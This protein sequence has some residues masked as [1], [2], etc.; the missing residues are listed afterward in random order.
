MRSLFVDERRCIGCL[1]CKESCPEGKIRI[2]DDE[3]REIIFPS[4]CGNDCTICEEACQEKAISLG[5]ERPGAPEI[6]LRFHLIPCED[7]LRGFITEPMLER[8][9][10][11]IP[12]DLQIDSSGLSWLRLCP[13]CRR[14]LERERMAAS[15]LRR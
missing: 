13:S 5:D 3:V 15:H 8:L 10:A 1:A 14:A 7:C 12:R 4:T 6:T 2:M 11:S 9:K